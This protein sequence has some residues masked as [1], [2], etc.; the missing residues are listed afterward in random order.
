MLMGL[1]GGKILSLHT[2]TLKQYPSSGSGVWG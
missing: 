2:L 1:C